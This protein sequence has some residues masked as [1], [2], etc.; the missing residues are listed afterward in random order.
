[1]AIAVI[2]SV[3]AK[4][5]HGA[6]APRRADLIR[7]Q[8]RL[9]TPLGPEE[10]LERAQPAGRTGSPR[11]RARARSRSSSGSR[12][13][14]TPS[15]PR[16]RSARPGCGR[17]S[18]G[19]DP[20]AGERESDRAG[21][22]HEGGQGHAE[23]SAS[24]CEGRPRQPVGRTG[25]RPV[26]ERHAGVDVG[27]DGGGRL[28]P[29]KAARSPAPPPS[30][31]HRRG[32][33]EERPDAAGSRAEA[34]QPRRAPADRNGKGASGFQLARRRSAP[35][36]GAGPART[37]SQPGAAIR[38]RANR[39]RVAPQSPGCPPPTRPAPPA[40]VARNPSGR[41]DFIVKES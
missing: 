30:T 1:M 17:R 22:R 24:P 11:R 8:R 2:S 16:R 7:A 23:D 6:E 5:G 3:P 41:D 29:R 36:P 20:P 40:R 38:A 33:S 26:E 34:A 15:G 14:S 21:D 27:H 4:T 19:G 31:R 37:R 13:S 12:R 25:I 18:S 28:V 10:E 35:A 39:S 9:R 32:A